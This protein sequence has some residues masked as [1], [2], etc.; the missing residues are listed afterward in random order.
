M[1]IRHIKKINGPYKLMVLVF[2]LLGIIFS[3]WELIARPFAHSYNK[4]LAYFS[5][6]T[7]LESHDLLEFLLV[8]YA[9]FYLVILAIIAVQFVFRYATLCKPSMTRRFGGCSVIIW[10]TY[11]MFSGAVYGGSLYYLCSPDEFSDHY[12]RR[13]IYDYYNL[14]ITH[15]PRF[16]IVPYANDNS[17]RWPNLHFLLIGVMILGLQYFIIIFCGVRLNTILKQQLRQLSTENRKLQKQIFK[18]LV[19]QTI[20]PILLFVLPIAPFLV[21]PLLDIEMNFPA[22]WMY[23]ILC[24][25]PPIDT[26]T[27]MLIV[28][29]YKR[30]VLVM[31][32]PVLPKGIKL[33]T[34]ISTSTAIVLAR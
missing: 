28:S 3:V 5:M 32:R 31:L 30:T 19:V 26:I 17:V 10:M 2:S 7:W 18:A 6:N 8:G 34:E 29:E 12:M 4:G 25:Y 23:V 22:G 11:I 1:T 15:I 27:Y 24:L 9:S 13:I 20:V 16:M 33:S 21:G 14:S